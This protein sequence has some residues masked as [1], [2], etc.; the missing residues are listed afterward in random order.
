MYYLCIQKIL[1]YLNIYYIYFGD[2]VSLSS[3]YNIN[4]SVI[5]WEILRWMEFL[6]WMLNFV[7][8]H[9]YRILGAFAFLTHFSFCR[10]H[11]MHL[12][13]IMM[14]ILIFSLIVNFEY[15]EPT[16]DIFH[17]YCEFSGEI[18]NWTII[19]SVLHKIRWTMFYVHGNLLITC[20]S[21]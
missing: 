21:I 3:S 8:R 10:P 5:I 14:F 9:S 12:N 11:R 6:F 20:I 7:I 18:V 16:F 15:C 19:Y 1:K 2:S 4:R 17:S 13:V